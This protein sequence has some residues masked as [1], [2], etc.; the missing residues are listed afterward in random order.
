MDFLKISGEILCRDDCQLIGMP[1]FR[2]AW[3]AKIIG[4]TRKAQKN[5]INW[6]YLAD[7]VPAQDISVL[8]IIFKGTKG[9][10]AL[11]LMSYNIFLKHLT[12]TFIQTNISK[13][14]T[15]LEAKAVLSD[16]N[17]KSMVSRN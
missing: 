1:L 15:D 9:L 13:F 5:A 8:K 14:S 12:F 6:N 10:S 2:L 16:E 3:Q 11:F 17:C 7:I 4:I